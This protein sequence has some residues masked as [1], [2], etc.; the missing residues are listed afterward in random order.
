MPAG[1]VYKLTIMAIMHSVCTFKIEDKECEG[2][3][4]KLVCCL[5]RKLLLLE[6]LILYMYIDSEKDGK[7]VDTKIPERKIKSSLP[8]SLP[9]LYPSVY[10]AESLCVSLI[11]PFE[12]Q[13]AASPDSLMFNIFAVTLAPLSQ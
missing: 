13:F 11:E 2:K 6:N 3:K 9:Q 10:A 12:S 4:Y 7:V 8:L 5:G 1:N